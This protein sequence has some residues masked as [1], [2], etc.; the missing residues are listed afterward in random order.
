MTLQVF[1][2][3]RRGR[4]LTVLL[5]VAMMAIAAYFAIRVGGAL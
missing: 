2:R 4:T 1:P 3:P 5:S